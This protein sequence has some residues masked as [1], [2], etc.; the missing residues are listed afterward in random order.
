MGI[1]KPIAELGEGWVFV[2]NLFCVIV[3]GIIGTLIIVKFLRKVLKKWKDID[4]A[5]INFIVNSVRVACVMV[6]TAIVLQMF[7]VSMTAIVAVLGTAGAAIALA[8]RDSLANIAGGV[9]IIV[10]HPF[11]QGD[12]VKIG[13]HR[14]IIEHID[15]FLTTMKTTD[16]QTVTIPNSIINT[17]VVYNETNRDTRRVDCLYPIAYDADVKKAKEI[18]HDICDKSDLILNEPTPW[19]GISDYADSGLILEC[20]FYCRQGDQWT[21]RYYMNEAVNETFRNEGIEI[22]YPHMDV[23]MK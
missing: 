1:F 22:P 19:I 14:G 6:L 18:L 12:I 17:S 23:K 10:T 11:E 20:L 13:E 5:I 3:G 15:L 9:M 16:Y 21:S 2:I 8:L 4:S 7:G